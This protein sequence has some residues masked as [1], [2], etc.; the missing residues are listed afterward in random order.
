MRVC[1][2]GRRLRG[3]GACTERPHCLLGAP[4]RN[5]PAWPGSTAEGNSEEQ[6]GSC[7]TIFN[8][9]L[10]QALGSEKQVPPRE[11][12]AWHSGENHQSLCST[13]VNSCIAMSRGHSSMKG[14]GFSFISFFPP[15]F[16]VFLYAV[17][18]FFLLQFQTTWSYMEILHRQNCFAALQSP[19]GG[20]QALLPG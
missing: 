13:A 19:G 8:E 11:L 6:R 4:R 10:A 14:C 9:Q 16:W 17:V 20:A 5:R 7:T 2:C 1:Y 3:Q 18:A 15:F 12:E